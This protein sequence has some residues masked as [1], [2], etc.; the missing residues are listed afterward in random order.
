MKEDSAESF[1]GVQ[2]NAIFDSARSIVFL[3]TDLFPCESKPTI[4]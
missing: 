1:I 2:S 4:P 3:R